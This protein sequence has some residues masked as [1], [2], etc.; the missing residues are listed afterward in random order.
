VAAGIALAVAGALACR[1]GAGEKQL[2]GFRFAGVDLVYALLRVASAS[3]RIFL[4]D[5]VRPEAFTPDLFLERVDIDLPPASLQDTLARLQE[6]TGRFE[7][8]IDPD[9]IYVRSDAA[10]DQALALDAKVLTDAE[11]KG[12]FEDLGNWIIARLPSAVI[13]P[14]PAWGQ[15]VHAQVELSIRGPASVLDVLTLYARTLGWGWR[16]QRAGYKT[17]DVPEQSLP[18]REGGQRSVYVLSSIVQW[19]PLKEPIK[20]YPGRDELTTL[21]T[22]ASI[23]RRTGIPVCAIDRSLLVRNRGN[24]DMWTAKDPGT[25]TLDE[26]FP[27]LQGPSWQQRFR[28]VKHDG[29]VLVHSDLYDFADTGKGTMKQRVEGGHFEGSLPEFARWVNAHMKGESGHVLMGGE[30]KGDEKRVAFDVE[31]DSTVEEA[32]LAFTRASGE[33]WVFVAQEFARG[34]KPEAMGMIEGPWI[35]GFLTYLSDWLEPPNRNIA[36]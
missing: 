16:I 12:D 18:T 35:G 24:L 5:E 11:F 6:A 15:P 17:E 10:W 29:I 26:L 23:S 25:G 22:M 34:E 20:V 2:P 19:Q 13:T 14:E 30:I 1:Q 21:R 3:D 27:L 36:Y 9:V 28:F 4:L 7:F 33:G 8:R 32:L 31:D